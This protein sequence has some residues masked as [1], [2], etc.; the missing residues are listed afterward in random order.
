MPTSKLSASIYLS[1]V[2]LSG[3]LVGG[4]FRRDNRLVYGRWPIPEAF[5]KAITQGL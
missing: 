4:V 1:L 3:I 2:F 5:V